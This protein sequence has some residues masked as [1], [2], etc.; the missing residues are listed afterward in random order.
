[1]KLFIILIALMTI[2]KTIISSE[3]IQK[4]DLFPV[5]QTTVFEEYLKRAHPHFDHKKIK[6]LEAVSY[7]KMVFA[8]CAVGLENFFPREVASKILNYCI[9]DYPKRVIQS[10]NRDNYFSCPVETKSYKPLSGP[11]TIITSRIYLPFFDRTD[12]QYKQLDLLQR[13]SNKENANDYTAIIKDTDH[14]VFKKVEAPLFTLQNIKTGNIQE[15]PNSH[16]WAGFISVGWYI[17]KLQYPY[18]FLNQKWDTFKGFY[19]L[20]QIINL[21]NLK[22][23]LSLKEAE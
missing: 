10:L 4:T 14:I 2:T 5:I 15:I 22:E 23:E 7:D 13:N 8:E 16:A 18:V 9:Y 1:M 17:E 20:Y 21:E 11:T 6:Q 19:F 3:T 12:H